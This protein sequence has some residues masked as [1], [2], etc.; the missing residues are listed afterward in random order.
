MLRIAFAAAAL[1]AAVFAARPHPASRPSIARTPTP[2]PIARTIDVPTT[3]PIAEA[4]IVS[5]PPSKTYS[6]ND[7]VFVE[8]GGSLWPATVLAAL[9]DG[10]VVARYDRA[11]STTD[12]LVTAS[13]VRTEQRFAR[14]PL[15]AAD[16][17]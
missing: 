4:P 10:R 13:R 6:E 12:E 14:R 11:A 17:L 15:L 16:A 9:R 8:R 5:S 3:I 7:R 2:P 1:A